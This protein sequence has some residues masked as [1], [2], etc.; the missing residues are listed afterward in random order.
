[1]RTELKTRYDKA[2][3]FYN[4]ANILKRDNEL[5]LISYFTEV[6]IIKNKKA[7]V[8]GDYSQ[9]TLRHIK[10]FLKQNG[11]KSENKKQILKD[12]GEKE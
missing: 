1:M 6:C 3:S 2:K 5:I 4:K 11:F 12:Y 9:T 10:E 7:F 8:K